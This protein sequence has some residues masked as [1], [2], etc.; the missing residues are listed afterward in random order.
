MNIS[1][2]L[3]TYLVLVEEQ[4]KKTNTENLSIYNGLSGICLVLFEIYL[5]TKSVKVKTLLG[6]YYITI[7]DAFKTHKFKNNGFYTGRLGVAYFLIR[8]QRE[9]ELGGTFE[10]IEL[11]KEKEIQSGDQ[12]ELLNGNAGE[13]LGYLLLHS[14]TRE[15]YC[16]HQ[17]ETKLHWLLDQIK[18]GSQGVFW[19]YAPHHYCSLTG[20]GHGL[21]GVA[22][23]LNQC[24]TYFKNTT[25]SL[26][27]DQSILNE[28]LHYHKS[29]DNWIDRRKAG[30]IELF[31]DYLKNDDQRLNQVGNSFAWCY[32]SP[33]I[34]L[35]RL[36]LTDSLNGYHGLK[37]SF[38]E[39]NSSCLC[40]GV[41]GNAMILKSVSDAFGKDESELLDKISKALQNSL[42]TNS[43][44]K[45]EKNDLSLFTGLSGVIYFLIRHKYASSEPFLLAPKLEKVMTDLKHD[46]I[47][48][49]TLE[50]LQNRL[51]QQAFPENDLNSKL[52]SG[53]K[54]DSKQDLRHQVLTQVDALT[55]DRKV[56]EEQVKR[57][58][59][60]HSFLRDTKFRKERFERVNIQDSSRLKQNE[61]FLL[62]ENDLFHVY[63]YPNMKKIRLSAIELEVLATFEKMVEVAYS[64]FSDD[65]ETRRT[66][67]H[68]Y[69]LG[70]VQII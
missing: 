52:P 53:F 44:T 27:A 48:N 46:S 47:I 63:L 57:K 30:T 40:H 64:L 54:L 12:S 55:N 24:A 9:F 56:Y 2:F 38:T 4:L 22:F 70:I 35:S 58:D 42:K 18:I 23:V 10:I 32:G 41:A 13:I 65:E 43:P 5:R 11:L 34:L 1:S 31:L 50:Q 45:T 26:L 51:I 62:L 14:L 25:W 28:D 39:L 33:G 29:L 67:N 19:N 36:S 8:Y 3:T 61:N 37:Q 60:F 20:F 6:K 7:Q 66:V 16:V 17:I 15:D 21:S 49:L 69:E 59:F 68:L